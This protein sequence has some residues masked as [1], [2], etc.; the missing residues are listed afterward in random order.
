M[1]IKHK[2]NA[3]TRAYIRHY[4]DNSQTAAYVEWSDGGRTEAEAHILGD[5]PGGYGWLFTTGTH[6][7]ALLARATREG[8]AIEREMW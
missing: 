4:S 1:T 6:M 8:I 5:K 3:I 2:Q 7:T